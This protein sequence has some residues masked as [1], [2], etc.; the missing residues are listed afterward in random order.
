MGTPDTIYENYLKAA[1]SIKSDTKILAITDTSCFHIS[2]E[3]AW[4]ASSLPA[5]APKERYLQS[6]SELGIANPQ[7][8]FN[9]LLSIGALREKSGY[10]LANLL[11]M[12]LAPKIGLVSSQLQERFLVR[13]SSRPE[14][15][16][17]IL[18]VLAPISAAGLFWGISL[19]L[20]GPDKVHLSLS[21]P[22][23]AVA[24][25]ALV[26]VGSLVHELGHSL[27][28]MSAGIG[29]R[30][31]G[32][33]VY[34][35]YPVFCTNVSGIEKLRLPERALIDCGGFIFQGTFLLALLLICFFSGNASFAEASRWISAI[36]LFNLNPFFRTDG[37]WL[38]KDIYSEFHKQ[39]LARVLHYGYLASFLVFS[40]W[41]FWLLT[42]RIGALWYSAVGM[43]HSPGNFF[44]EGYRAII[45]GY[46]V[47][48]GLL[49]GLNRFK[50]GHAEWIELRK[51]NN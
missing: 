25:M 9:K 7:K 10:S 3:T 38:Y 1:Y 33:S 36:I 41:F 44:S 17:R 32:V 28:A 48:L 46:L 8:I 40:I 5:I 39:R 34:L 45:G 18:R 14:S 51:S 11:K 24:V 35:V 22:P 16:G 31:I 4:L 42:G 30:P 20:A 13:F 43:I 21:G 37:Y 47:F 23:D 50:E 26:I 27:A 2:Q 15:T 12:L 49:G 29:L 19:I 6:L